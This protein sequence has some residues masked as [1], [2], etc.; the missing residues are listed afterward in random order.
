MDIY[1]RDFVAYPSIRVR[2]KQEMCVGGIRQT[3]TFFGRKPRQST[4][5]ASGRGG[6]GFLS[7][8]NK[9]KKIPLRVVHN[10]MKISSGLGK[11]RRREENFG[12]FF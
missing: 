2:P 11:N 4:K 3:G 10:N 5:R 7:T 9:K 1:A 8:L 6:G 12:R